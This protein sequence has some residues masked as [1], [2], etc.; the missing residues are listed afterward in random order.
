MKTRFHR[1]EEAVAQLSAGGLRLEEA[2]E[3]FEQG[4]ALAELLQRSCSTRRNCACSRWA[5]WRP[6]IWRAASTRPA[7]RRAAGR[8]PPDRGPLAGPGAAWPAC[9]PPPAR[10]ASPPPDA[11]LDPLFDDI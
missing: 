1:L 4:M 10:S 11:P 2:L 3:R 6:R 7:A 5:N 9:P 8:A